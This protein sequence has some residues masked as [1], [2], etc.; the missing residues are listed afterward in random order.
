MS[1][2]LYFPNN[3]Y[4]FAEV[5]ECLLMFLLNMLLDLT[6]ERDVFYGSFATENTSASLYSIFL[7]HIKLPPPHPGY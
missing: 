6:D 2:Y 5:I 7:Y 4:H 3:H 1:G